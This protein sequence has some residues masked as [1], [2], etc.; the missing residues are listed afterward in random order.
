MVVKESGS[1]TSVVVGGGVN[2][3]TRAN[4]VRNMSKHSRVSRVSS[5]HIVED[6]QE[7][8]VVLEG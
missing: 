3:L 6:S 5:I 1:R 2:E 8:Q 4:R 7:G